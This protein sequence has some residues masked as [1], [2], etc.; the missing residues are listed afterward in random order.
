MYHFCHFVHV[1]CAKSH[2]FF[3]KC[4]YR[5]HKLFLFSTNKDKLRFEIF[6]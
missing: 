6:F 2:E 5:T 4:F 3:K 1:F